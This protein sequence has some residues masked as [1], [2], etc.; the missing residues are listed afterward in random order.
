MAEKFVLFLDVLGFSELVLNNSQELLEKICDSDLRQTAAASTLLAAAMTGNFHLPF[1]V[2]TSEQGVL[3]DVKQDHINFHLMSDSLIAWANDCSLDA[4]IL[5]TNF[6]AQYLAQTLTLG[7]PHRGAISKGD[8]KIID[9]PLNG[10]PQSNA[11]GSGLVKA[12]RFEGGQE[13]MGCVIDS[14]C[15]AGFSSQF[16]ADWIKHPQSSLTTYDVPYKQSADFRSMLVVD[17]RIPFK[18]F[19]MAAG[20]G[21]FQ[22]QFLRYNKSQNDSVAI[23]ID[24]TYKFFEA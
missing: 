12:H 17:W 7:L 20:I 14:E 10:R 15:V 22:E 3:L 6:A 5:L 2:Q 8:I 16:I 24:N 4:L 1:N 21:Y 18:M 19:G 23:K 13:W 11:V 9:L